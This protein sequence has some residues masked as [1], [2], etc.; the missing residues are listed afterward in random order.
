MI[1]YNQRN[2][3]SYKYFFG[4]IN[5]RK[6]KTDKINKTSRKQHKVRRI[7]VC[8]VFYMGRQFKVILGI[9]DVNSRYY[10]NGMV[11]V[12]G[13]FQKKINAFQ[14]D[15]DKTIINEILEAVEMDF[16]S[17]TSRTRTTD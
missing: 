4:G 13:E 9:R 15:G 12:M 17:N 16:I 8:S 10:F 7:N 5:L 3:T 2:H 14:I 11:K 6:N 1:V